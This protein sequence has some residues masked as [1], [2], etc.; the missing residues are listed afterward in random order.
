MNIILNLKIL[1]YQN[2]SKTDLLKAKLFLIYFT[3][4]NFEIKN[5]IPYKVMSSLNYLHKSLKTLQLWKLS[6]Y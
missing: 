3:T 6:I 1:E 4:Y 2:I 5:N